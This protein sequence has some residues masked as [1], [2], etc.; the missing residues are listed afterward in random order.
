[1]RI[2][3]LLE[4][5]GQPR[6]VYASSRWTKDWQTAVQTPDFEKNF[7]EWLA[8]WQKGG[9][10][11]MPYDAK[12]KPLT[13][14]GDIQRIKIPNSQQSQPKVRRWHAIQGKVIVLYQLYPDA[15]FLIAV[16]PHDIEEKNN[17]DIIAG[18]LK[19]L[20][21]N[22]W[23]QWEKP[24]Q[25]PKPEVVKKAKPLPLSQEEKE[26]ISELFPLLATDREGQIVLLQLSR[27]DVLP[28]LMWAR[29]ALGADPLDTSRD[30][31][32]LT[33]FDGK[34]ALAKLA[35]RYIPTT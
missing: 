26:A 18:W 10:S 19:K 24:I 30:G 32:I 2:S 12:D 31:F 13:G 29:A 21:R 16:G 3:E 11:H 9:L 17:L 28:W 5:E 27:Q 23:K 1:M 8:H 14:P 15:V 7:D 20:T 35:S 22:E 25:E 6:E 33:A 4:Q 34:K